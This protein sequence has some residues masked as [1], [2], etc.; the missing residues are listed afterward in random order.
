M[1]VAEDATI[2]SVKETKYSKENHFTYE[3][4]NGSYKGNWLDYHAGSGNG[5]VF[6]ESHTFT[7]FDIAIWQYKD[8]QL[9]ALIGKTVGEIPV[10][11]E[12]DSS[13]IYACMRMKPFEVIEEAV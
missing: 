8:N 6:A 9:R 12:E 4:T 5:G 2:F 13:Y 10:C 1:A 7:E 3:V 11:G